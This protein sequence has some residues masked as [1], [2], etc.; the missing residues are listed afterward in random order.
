MRYGAGYFGLKGVLA[1][2]SIGSSKVP[3]LVFCVF[4]LM[5]AAITYVDPL[6]AEYLLFTHGIRL[7]PHDR[8]WCHC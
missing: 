8:H 7:Q 1:Q 5:F 4:Q 3:A 2:P 6:S